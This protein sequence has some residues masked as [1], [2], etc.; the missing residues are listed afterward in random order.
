MNKYIKDVIKLLFIY[1]IILFAW[2]YSV[3]AAIS[4]PAT[5]PTS[6]NSNGEI[7][8]YFDKVLDSCATWKVLTWYNKSTGKICTNIKY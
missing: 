5:Q 1:W 8:K 2:Y 6:E 4:W 7:E 3:L